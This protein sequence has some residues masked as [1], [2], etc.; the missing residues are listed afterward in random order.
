MSKIIIYGAACVLALAACATPPHQVA[1]TSR[2]RA[3]VEQAEQSGAQQFASAD[4]EAARNKLQVA[5]DKHTDDEVAVRMAQESAADAEVALA[6][7]RAGK[8]QQALSQVS[9][10]SATLRQE[11]NRPDQPASGS[12]PP[13]P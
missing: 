4:L 8:A 6:R 13:R 5:Q 3:L 12:P 1:E 9:A 7:S 10:G 2:A 11:A